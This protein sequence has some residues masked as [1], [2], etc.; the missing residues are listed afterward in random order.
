MREREREKERE[1]CVYWASIL[2]D[3]VVHCFTQSIT[4][5]LCYSC[6]VFGVYF[7]LYFR[8]VSYVYVCVQWNS[9]MRMEIATR[10]NGRTTKDT[11]EV[12]AFIR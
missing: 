6:F 3:G 8:V 11:A 5:A 9:F 1:M 12:N 4:F 10:A 2:T 7:C